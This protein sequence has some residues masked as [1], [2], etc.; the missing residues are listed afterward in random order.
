M[1]ETVASACLRY[2]YQN[3]FQS[4]AAV[5]LLILLEQSLFFGGSKQQTFSD[6]CLAYIFSHPRTFTLNG[7]SHIMCFIINRKII[8]LLKH[9]GLA[10]AKQLLDFLLPLLFRFKVFLIRFCGGDKS[11][12]AFWVGFGCLSSDF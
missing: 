7:V 3:S 1:Q 5:W 9:G 11:E 4:L 12:I 2:P 6:L 8:I 10:E